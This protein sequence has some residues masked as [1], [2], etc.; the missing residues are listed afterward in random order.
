MPKPKDWRGEKW[1][2]RKPGSY[3]WYETQD[4]IDYY[5]EFEKAK[6]IYA[7]I[8][9]KGQFTLDLDCYYSDTTSYIIGSDS[10]YLLGIL[11]SKL[12]TFLFS[13]ISSEIRGGFYRWKRQYMEILPIR[14][15]DFSNPAEKAQHDKLVALV[16]NMLELKKKYHEMRMD[17]DK[18]L[19]ERQIKI[20]DAQ[21]DRLVYELYRLTEEEVKVLETAF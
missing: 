16:E 12:W 6:I 15:I 19:Y 2:G 17:Q 1:R 5:L 18:E 9:V 21:I 13:C 11:N 20:V 8:A 7:E 14:T 10:R 4:S 3:K